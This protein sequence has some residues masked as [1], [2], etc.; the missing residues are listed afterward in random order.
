M[1]GVS[2]IIVRQKL[3]HVWREGDIHI[4]TCD[5]PHSVIRFKEIQD[6][7]FSKEKMLLWQGRRRSIARGWAMALSV[8]R[9]CSCSGQKELQ[10]NE[11]HSTASGQTEDIDKTIPE[12]RDSKRLHQAI[13]LYIIKISIQ[14][15]HNHSSPN[16]SSHPMTN[17]IISPFL[18]TQTR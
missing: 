15:Y 4:E 18:S 9:W 6:S 14:Y 17:F 7:R 1:S 3:G 13:G 10:W 16:Q 12:L 2:R 11:L 5:T 8:W